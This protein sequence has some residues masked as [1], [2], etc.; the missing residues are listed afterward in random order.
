VLFAIL[1]ALTSLDLPSA[2][3]PDTNQQLIFL[4]SLAVLIFVLFLALTFVLVRNVLKLFAER[5]L[6]VLGSK[7]RT[8]MLV[9]SLL[10]SFLPAIGMFFFAYV[11]MNRSIDKWFSTPVEEVRRDTGTMA[12]QLSEYAAQNAKAEATSIALSHTVERAFADGDFSSVQEV[13]SHHAATLQGGFAVALDHGEA[14][15]TF[16]TPAPWDSLKAQLPPSLGVFTWGHTDYSLASVPVG[17][18]GRI[19]VGVPLPNRF[20]DTVKQIE[21]SQQ[22]YL[23]L[24]R[25]RRLVRRTYMEV[26]LL[27]TVVVLFASTWLALFLS[28]L[29]TRPVVALAEATQ[30]ISR[31][32][33][34]YR[35]EVQA[36]ADEIGDLVRSFNRM[37]EELESNRRQ[38]EASSRELSAANVALEQRR[39]QIETI[40]ESIPNGV[41]SMNAERRI[42]HVNHALLRLLHPGGTVSGTPSVLIGASLRDVFSSEILE[43]LEPLLRRADR[44]GTTTTQMEMTADRRTVDV[45]IT[46]ATLQHGGQRLGYVLVF[47]DLSDLLKAQKQAAWR[48]VARRVAHEIKNPLTPIALSA[49]R[50][51]R[52]LERHGTS[53]PSSRKV[54]QSSAETISA[55]V[56]TVRSLVDEFATLARFPTAQPRPADINTIVDSVLSMFDGQL[57]NISVRTRLAV[58]LPPVMADGEA[59][60][61]AL[62]NLIDNAAEAMQDAVFREI[63]IYTS[64]VSSRDA[65]EIIVADSGHGVT[66]ELKERLFLPY[67]STKKRGTGLGLAI[68][69]RIIEDHHGTIRVEEN[70]PVGARFIIELPVVAETVAASTANQHA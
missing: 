53:D 43:N 55:S 59:M 15:A 32:R 65:V 2:F 61:R 22:R 16:G 31:G 23:D 44:M 48:E 26:L 13:F 46:V 24:A 51:Q 57:E 58:E 30:E 4:A 14:K 17:D 49:E 69:S 54:I 1:F 50:I 34:D 37:A 28:K 56:E 68:V 62:A 19:L 9:G 41:L 5:R 10:L 20:L 7:F 36:A 64:L 38:I 33:L 25:G 52:H 11:L 6:G 35:V 60:K 67:F 27:L 47:E 39:R 66:P 29:V 21:L 45:A 3:T 63:Q 12:A 40:L 18:N 70:R 42:T 8:R